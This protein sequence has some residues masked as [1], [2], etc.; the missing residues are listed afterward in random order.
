MGFAVLNPSYNYYYNYYILFKQ[1][2][3]RRR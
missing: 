1:P 2:G 3:P